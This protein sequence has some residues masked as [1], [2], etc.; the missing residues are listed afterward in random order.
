M[1]VNRVVEAKIDAEAYSAKPPEAVVCHSTAVN[2]AA[3]RTAYGMRQQGDLFG[4]A[5]QMCGM[6]VLTLDWL[7]PDEFVIFE[8][9]TRAREFVSAVEQSARLGFNEN[10]IR[11][12]MKSWIEKA[13]IRR[14]I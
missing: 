11:F 4:H 12:V 3:W 8:T 9:V 2:E 10:T 13:K 5:N 7:R 14:A 1:N 6:E